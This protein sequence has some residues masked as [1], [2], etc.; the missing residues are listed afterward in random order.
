MADPHEV[1]GV[2]SGADEATVRSAY[3]E[4]LVEHHPDQGGSTER[5]L[6]IKD[7]YE[8]LTEGNA[9]T[10]PLSDGGTVSATRKRVEVSAEAVE[11]D[12]GLQLVAEADGLVV[13]L[14]ALTDRLATDQV[15]PDHVEGGRRVGAS[16]LVRNETGRLVT[17][18]ARRVRFVDPRGEHYLPTVYRP[19]RRKLPDRWRGDDVELEP[20]ETA[21]SFLLS[22]ELPE[23]VDVDAVLYDQ[24]SSAGP[25]RRVE[26]SLDEPA[27][28]ALDRQPFQ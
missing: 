2:P 22:R 1:L 19:K 7:A 10:R 21:R 17:W 14:V 11:A 5:F 15:L 24:Q 25:A 23:D 3:R 12:D 13:R 9:I 16:F 20:G 28:T 4:L 26:F 8:R 6:R 27:R 18:K